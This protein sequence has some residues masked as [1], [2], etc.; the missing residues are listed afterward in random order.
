MLNTI[1]SKTLY[2]KRW[3]ALWWSLSMF[4]F[5]L[6]IVLL[7]P[8]FRDSFGQALQN[9]PESLKAVLGE[10]SDYQR[11][12]GF[13]EL[14]VFMQM[15]FLTFIYGIILFSGLIAGEEND[16][17]LQSLLVQPVSRTK[18]YLHKLA[19]GMILLG[20][21]S[22][23]LFLGCWLGAAVINEPTNVVR[24]LQATCMQWL[25]SLVLSLV[26]YCLGAILGRRGVAGALAGI[27]AFVSYMLFSLASTATFLK[28]ANNFSPFHYYSNPRILDNGLSAYNITILSCACVVLIILGWL[29]FRQRDIYQR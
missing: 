3:G 11:I 1:F 25:V 28:T 6:L 17:T 21:V 8:T 9:V 20:V 5:T 10:A 12:E 26:A 7:F 2:E 27:Y 22:L 16:G 15:I 29:R 13:M 19:A 4:T 18:I 23:A 14:Q 24:L